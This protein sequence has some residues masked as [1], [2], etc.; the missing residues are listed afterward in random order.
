MV[1]WDVCVLGFVAGA[2]GSS[3][4]REGCSGGRRE[5]NQCGGTIAVERTLFLMVL[6]LDVA[7]Q[8]KVKRYNILQDLYAQARM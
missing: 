2:W 4:N 3:G 5:R 8:F 1:G 7:I 6:Y